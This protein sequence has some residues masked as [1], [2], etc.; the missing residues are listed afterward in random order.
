MRSNWREFAAIAFDETFARSCG[1]YPA[2]Q[3]G[4]PSLNRAAVRIGV[5]GRMPVEAAADGLTKAGFA[6][7]NRCGF[8]ATVPQDCTAAQSIRWKSL[9]FPG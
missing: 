6:G 3:H 4:K 8:P 7:L 9:R 5:T 2:P 1:W